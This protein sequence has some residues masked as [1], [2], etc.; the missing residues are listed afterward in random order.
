MTVATLPSEETLSFIEDVTLVHIAFKPIKGG[1]HKYEI[2][3]FPKRHGDT[4]VYYDSSNHHGFSPERP[5]K[6]VWLAHGLKK[7]MRIVIKVKD[8]KKDS[9]L[10][11]QTK[12]EIVYPERVAVGMAK[13]EG[14]WQYSVILYEKDGNGGHAVVVGRLDP[15]VVVKPDP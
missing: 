7:G 14:T 6:V 10:L 12:Y 8:E 9:K 3:V 4:T 15:E 11:D 2:H 13:D 1:K 5:R